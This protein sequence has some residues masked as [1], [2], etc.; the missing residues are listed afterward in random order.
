MITVS[1]W[2][3]EGVSDDRDSFVPTD[4]TARVLSD[5][6]VYLYFSNDRVDRAQAARDLDD[7]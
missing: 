5:A 3:Y 1:R 6:T 7:L 4:T 2:R